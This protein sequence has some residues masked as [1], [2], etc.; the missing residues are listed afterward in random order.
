MRWKIVNYQSAR[1]FEKDEESNVG[2]DNVNSNINEENGDPNC[3]L[4][5]LEEREGRL[6]EQD[7]DLDNNMSNF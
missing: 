2:G 4:S 3:G 6:D 7:Y 5:S 1:I